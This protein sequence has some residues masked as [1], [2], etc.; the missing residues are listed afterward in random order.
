[1]RNGGRLADMA[2]TAWR[3]SVQQAQREAAQMQAQQGGDG[4]KTDGDR[5][6]REAQECKERWRKRTG[7]PWDGLD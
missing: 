4:I 3:M 1:M 7:E 6:A 5:V 2:L